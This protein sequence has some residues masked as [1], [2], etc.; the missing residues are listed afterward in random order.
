M[1]LTARALW[2]APPGKAYLRDETLA[3]PQPDE[4]VVRTYYS[5]VSRG[6]ETLVYGGHVPESE[7]DRM[8]APFQQGRLPNPIKHGYANVGRVEDGPVDWIGRFVFCLF[9]HQTRYTVAPSDAV[10]LPADVPPARA[11]LAAGME[12]A[13]NALWDAGPRVGDRI[14]VVGAGVIGGLVA[15]LC[16]RLPGVKVQIV[17]SCAERAALAEAFGTAFAEPLHAEPDRDLVFHASG[18][19]AGLETALR[20]AGAE[21]EIIELSWYGDRDV[22]VPL[23]GAFHARRLT[24]RASQVS[25]VSPAR[26]RRRSRRERLA[27]AVSMCADARLDALL[28]PVDAPFESLPAVMARL[29]NPADTTLCQRIIYPEAPPA[30]IT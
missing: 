7:Y 26:A 3:S 20:L 1:P 22:R 17:D 28:A 15:F 13:I 4:L 27:L 25:A 16:A 5:A 19:D 29:A 14:T 18:S 6:T 12:T 10:R 23:G 9:P 30:C 21:A 8:R 11:V 2:L 24:L